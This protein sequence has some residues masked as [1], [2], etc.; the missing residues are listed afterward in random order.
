MMKNSPALLRKGFTLLE[1]VIVIGIIAVLLAVAAKNFIGAGTLAE[2]KKAEADMQTLTTAI[3][4]YK[5]MG[6]SYPSEAQG[7]KALEVRPS[8]APKPRSWTQQMKEVPTD[9]WGNAYT[10][11]RS[12]S[13]LSNKPELITA[14]P[15]GIFGNED[16]ISSQD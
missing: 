16:D 8:T 5:I 2:V 15:D 4:S 6:G 1:M 11:K 3:E 10:Y 14:G 7:L 12:G 13:V 9:P